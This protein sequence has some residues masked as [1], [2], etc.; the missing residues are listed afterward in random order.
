MSNP[1]ERYASGACHETVPRCPRGD[2]CLIHRALRLRGAYV[3]ALRTLTEVNER[4]RERMRMAAFVRDVAQQTADSREIDASDVW[5]NML[6]AGRQGAA[7]D[8]DSSY[9]KE[10]IDTMEREIGEAQEAAEAAAEDLVSLLEQRTFQQHLLR[11][12]RDVPIRPSD[13]ARYYDVE[14]SEVCGPGE[15]VYR[16]IDHYAALF[17]DQLSLTTAGTEHLERLL[18]DGA[19]DALPGFREVWGYFQNAHSVTEPLGK[20]LYNVAPVLTGAITD[21][22]N[23]GAARSIR[24]VLQNRE[25]QPHLRFLNEKLGVD[26][27]AWVEQRAR[28]LGRRSR[29]AL[30]DINRHRNLQ[31]ALQRWNDLPEGQ[32]AGDLQKLDGAWMR[33]T[34]G[35]VS[36]AAASAKILTDWR[37]VGIKDWAGTIADFSSLAQTLGETF[38]TRFRVQG[39]LAR[40]ADAG[41]ETVGRFMMRATA[42]RGFAVGVGILAHTMG[43]VL[44]LITLAQGV[45][46]RDW[47]AVALASAGLLVS[48]VG[49]FATLAGA[50]VVS[51]ACTVI[52]VL[53]VV[54]AAVILDPPIIDYL[55]DTEW[56]EDHVIPL[57]ETI[58]EFYKKLFSL[59]IRFVRTD[60]ARFDQDVNESYIEIESYGLS[61]GLPVYVTIKRER[62][63]HTLGRT[64][65][66]PDRDTVDGRGRI[67]KSVDWAT[68]RPFG[69]RGIRI[70]R[71]WEIWTDIA[72]DDTTEY[73]LRAEMDPDRDNQMELT[74][75]DGG[76][77]F[78]LPQ[79]PQLLRVEPAHPYRFP[80]GVAGDERYLPYPSSGRA[81]YRV[82]TRYASGCR[83]RVLA[84]VDSFA[85]YNPD[86]AETTVS[87]TEETTT[88]DIP[89]V[90]P[91]RDDYYELMLTVDLQDAQGEH[92]EREL[93]GHTV[94]IRV[95]TH[96]YIHGRQPA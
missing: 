82:H 6:G 55:E 74:A 7:R 5:G 91:P 8:L 65:V 93:H 2:R 25:V 13:A 41:D 72:R 85:F 33:L 54:L 92:I 24:A 1:D 90:R 19:L 51:G 86:L 11:F 42:A 20:F 83:L 66:Y 61:D 96:E 3:N 14:I 60:D 88:V 89:L 79:R 64:A 56:G 49:F 35:I 95:A 47:D 12:H 30:R 16:E 68:D 70:H 76:V 28:T 71:P 81:S 87:V 27:N 40:M 32:L 67:A 21:L 62:D 29:S 45:Q 77:E 31:R 69:P 26:V 9:L 46:S 59:S 17:T 52:G 57:D 63:W 38:E 50:A 18:D 44:S 48:C 39:T 73:Y 15:P 10:D 84:E 37:Q 43:I 53:L 4:H 78:P 22:V 94:D 80:T 75:E 23:R 34:L 58:D 36:F